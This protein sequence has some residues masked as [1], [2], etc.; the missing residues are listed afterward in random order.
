MI[1]YLLGIVYFGLALE[2]FFIVRS[3][4]Y[5]R[6]ER[7]TKRPDYVPKAAIVAP[8]YGWDAKTEEHVKRVLDLD[9]AGTYE[10][11]F[12]THKIG[13][14]GY[15]VSY[16]HLLKIAEEYPNAHV[17]LAPNI[18][19][20]A[21]QRSQKV[22]NLITAIAALPDDVEII[23][24]VDADALIQ[25][26]W[27]TL[28]VQPLQDRSIGVTVGTR[29]Y[30]PYTNNLAS[31]VE[32]TWINFQIALQGDHPLTM[33]WGG[34]NAIRREFI[35]EGRVLERWENAAVEDH[36]VTHAVRDFKLKVHLVPDCITICRTEGRTWKQILE[37]DYS[38]C[39]E[40]R[41]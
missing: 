40:T 15:D 8:H 11:F 6:R 17:L 23:A 35:K 7:N 10:V 25:R 33:V 41:L 4:L 30:L 32:A 34:S 5:A 12:V 1:S 27:L 21:L 13:E 14:S 28:L 26:D 22:Q 24:F 3:H 9:Y 29:F 36:N 20:N 16:P 37:N 38:L 39:S 18:I 31:L 19:D 2:I